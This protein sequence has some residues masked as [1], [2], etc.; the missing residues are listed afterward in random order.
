MWGCVQHLWLGEQ[1]WIFSS[2]ELWDCIW[3]Y[4]PFTWGK[5]RVMTTNGFSVDSWVMPPVLSCFLLGWCLPSYYH[6]VHF[7]SWSFYEH[8][9]L[10][11]FKW[12]EPFTFHPIS[13][14]LP[15]ALCQL[16]TFLSVTEFPFLAFGEWH[17]WH[18]GI[19]QP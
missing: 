5:I 10:F 11:K 6:T 18:P 16:G 15:H 8:F 13:T 7:W 17:L 12:Q 9:L 4:L 3:E 1:S 19:T 14:L 2:D